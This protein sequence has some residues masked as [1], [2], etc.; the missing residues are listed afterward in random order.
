MS[1]LG[2][3]VA[4]AIF[5]VALSASM[6]LLGANHGGPAWSAAWLCLY[7]GG[8][9]MIPVDRGVT[10]FVPVAVTLFTAFAA[11]LFRG[12]SIFTRTYHDRIGALVGVT[13]AFIASRTAAFFLFGPQVSQTIGGI[14][15][16]TAVIASWWVFLRPSSGVVGPWNRTLAA[17]FVVVPAVTWM[18]SIVR[19]SGEPTLPL[20]VAWFLVGILICSLNT[21]AFVSLVSERLATLS[22]DARRS[23]RAQAELAARY[24]D[25]VEQASDLIAEFDAEGRMVYA[26]PA[27]RTILGID[28]TSLVGMEAKAIGLDLETHLTLAGKDGTAANSGATQ[29]I[30]LVEDATGRPVTLEYNLRP[31][32]SGDG[33]LHVVVTGRDV[34]ER[35]RRESDRERA[36]KDLLALV[37]TRSSELESSLRELQESQR[38]AAMGTM[39][40]GIAHQINNPIGSIRLAA[41]YALANE[42]TTR[43]SDNDND[44]D[45]DND[46]EVGILRHALANCVEQAERCG[47]I[48][49]S[50][51]QF[52]RN[53]SI[54]K[55]DEDLTRIVRSACD[56]VRRSPV[57]DRAV[58][59]PE[60]ELEATPIRASAIE[61]E[62][63]ILNV[64]HN[65]CEAGTSDGE[66][67]RVSIRLASDGDDAILRIADD[68]RG[69]T[70]EEAARVFDPFYTTRLRRGGTGLGLSVAHGIIEDHGGSLSVE[71]RPE[72]GTDVTI[73]LPLANVSVERVERVA[74]S[75]T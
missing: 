41:E 12:A 64:L 14:A 59:A 32:R 30:G 70:R 63:A 19:I 3:F 10:L 20:R 38:L 58:L 44:N 74:S 15:T 39:A 37:D 31:F 9:A 28:P 11:L 13:V 46:D 50:M 47:R 8:L 42:G 36:Q 62:Q 40:A 45:N 61:L 75:R 6:I 65:A 69:M 34:T 35:A 5:L 21:G 55:Q 29:H 2:L 48:V 43:D 23:E 66:S 52:A 7:A 26:N 57:A 22:K 73:R 72:V 49:A 16:T 67:V 51:L 4:A 68:G 25:L 71:S 24:D 33:S 53:E 56:L 17:A 18:Y 27:W 60:I 1:E 54:P